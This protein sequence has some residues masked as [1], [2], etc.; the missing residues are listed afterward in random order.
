MTRDTPVTFCDAAVVAHKDPQSIGS[1]LSAVLG[2]VARQTGSGAPLE[3]IWRALVGELIAR[4]SQVVALEQRVLTVRVDGAP[5]AS[6][7]ELE[8]ASLVARLNERLGAD[9]VRRL[10]FQLR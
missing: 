7:L 3:P 10:S 8:Q 9:T 4:H 2:Q 6:A 5:W 1:L